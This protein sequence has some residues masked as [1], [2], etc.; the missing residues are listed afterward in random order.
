M[1]LGRRVGE[2]HACIRCKPTSGLIAKRV[3][4]MQDQT[5]TPRELVFPKFSTFGQKVFH[6]RPKKCFARFCCFYLSI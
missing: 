5:L 2:E 3:N 1:V 4:S 6:F